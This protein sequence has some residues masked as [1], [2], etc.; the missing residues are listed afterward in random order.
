MTDVRLDLMLDNELKDY[1][2]WVVSELK[3]HKENYNN[4]AT[5]LKDLLVEISIELYTR[6]NHKGLMDVP[7]S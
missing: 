3:K 2:R 1:A 5:H 6:R 7:T 4:D